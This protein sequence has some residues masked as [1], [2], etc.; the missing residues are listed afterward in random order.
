MKLG[1]NQAMIVVTCPYFLSTVALLGV[2]IHARRLNHER[3]FVGMAII[4]SKTTSA[5]YL[6]DSVLWQYTLIAET[7]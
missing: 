4:L 2:L 5:L 6:K 3:H 7:W 1:I